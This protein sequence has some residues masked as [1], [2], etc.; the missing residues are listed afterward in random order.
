MANAKLAVVFRGVLSLRK[1]SSADLE[2]CTPQ[3]YSR[4]R[5]YLCN[6]IMAVG[7]YLCALNTARYWR[8]RN[9][10]TTSA[11]GLS[12]Y[13]HFL[14]CWS[15]TAYFVILPNIDRVALIDVGINFRGCSPH[16]CL[17]LTILLQ[18]HAQ[19]VMKK[20]RTTISWALYSQLWARLA[21]V[22]VKTAILN[23]LNL[24]ETVQ[25]IFPVTGSASPAQ[26]L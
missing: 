13:R 14:T 22:I 17:V 4:R 23:S 16:S 21:G 6:T 18:C 1:P 24:M 26:L 9:N 25:N 3:E 15:T 19:L 2:N 10:H 12:F 8:D 20:L 11:P 7:W 5:E